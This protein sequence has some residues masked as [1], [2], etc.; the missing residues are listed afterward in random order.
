M[1]K[2]KKKKCETIWNKI[3]NVNLNLYL[4]SLDSDVWLLQTCWLKSLKTT[5][6][7]KEILFFEIYYLYKVIQGLTPHGREKK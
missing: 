4:Q 2:K 3:G 1:A 6:E 5:R 7:H